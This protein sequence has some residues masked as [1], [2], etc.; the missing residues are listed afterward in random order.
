LLQKKQLYHQFLFF[1][2]FFGFSIHTDRY[3][4]PVPANAE[5]DHGE[6]SIK[7]IEK[8]IPGFHTKSPSRQG[9]HHPVTRGTLASKGRRLLVYNGS[10][11]AS[12]IFPRRSP[13]SA[14]AG[15]AVP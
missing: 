13:Y 12:E 5:E 11:A 4:N 6:K 3:A 15:R 9:I 2:T 8:S 7:K 1:A 10:R 14:A